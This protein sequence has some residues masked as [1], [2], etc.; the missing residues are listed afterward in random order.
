MEHIL[1]TSRGGTDALDHLAW[2]CPI[3]NAH[4]SNH[5]AGTDEAG[6]E[7]PLF[8]PRRDRWDVHFEFDPATCHLQGKTP[9]GQGTV[10]RLR[11]NAALRV[12]GRQ[13][14]VELGLYP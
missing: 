12:A 8:H 5:V 6:I 11:L 2:A 7:Q 14:W 3:C 9:K 10:N 1:P 4:K 13:L